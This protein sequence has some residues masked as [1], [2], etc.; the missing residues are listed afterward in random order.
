MRFY[1]FL[2]KKYCIAKLVKNSIVVQLL[3]NR[4]QTVEKSSKNYT[5]IDEKSFFNRLTTRKIR[6][7]VRFQQL[8]PNCINYKNT[9]Y[10]RL[11]LDL[12]KYN[13]RVGL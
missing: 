12:I 6:L 8:K 5:Q 3:Y 13:F 1:Y 10:I 7:T 2:R 4:Q 9:N 11:K